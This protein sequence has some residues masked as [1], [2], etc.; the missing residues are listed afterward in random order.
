MFPISVIRQSVIAGLAA[1]GTL[2][3]LCPAARSQ[4]A[5]ILSAKVE[6]L[7]L[8]NATMEEALRA[9]R[10][11]NPN[12]ILIGFERVPHRR[13]EP[14][15]RLSLSASSTTVEEILKAACGQDPRYAYDIAGG[16]VI[17]VRPVN[18]YAD[19]QDLLDMSVRDFSVDE[20]MSPAAVIS[21]IGELAPEL[22]SYMTDKKRE[23]YASRGIVP[24]SPGAQMHGNMDPQIKIHLQ[25]VTVRQIL[26]GVVVYSHELYENA[27]PDWTG[28]RPVPTSWIYD[29]TI[30]PAAPTGLG[31]YPVWIAF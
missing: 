1:L 27:K 15:A 31:G 30:D 18:S 23:Y 10:A 25:N 11:T 12:Q 20:V 26:N 13:D 24:A 7:T 8:Q 22:A 9:L 17:E 4:Q 29:F 2:L 14:E 5:S 6:G 19:P 21:R 16:K 3:S 28:N